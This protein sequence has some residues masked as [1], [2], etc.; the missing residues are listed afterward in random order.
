VAAFDCR[1]LQ[2]LWTLVVNPVPDHWPASLLSSY[3]WI[4]PYDA[5][6]AH[7]GI[8]VVTGISR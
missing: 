5:S 7:M 2:A 8:Y 3:K 6:S 4:I 1:H